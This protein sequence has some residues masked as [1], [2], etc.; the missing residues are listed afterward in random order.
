[1]E[2]R[3]ALRELCRPEELPWWDAKGVRDA[4]ITEAR[5]QL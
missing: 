3:M 2:P 5:D 4:T 1:M